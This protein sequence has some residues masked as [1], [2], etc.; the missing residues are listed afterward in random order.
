MIYQTTSEQSVVKKML[1]CK[2]P[3]Q[4]VLMGQQQKWHK[5]RRNGEQEADTH[6]HSSSSA[7]YV[8]YCTND[9]LR[10]PVYFQQ[11]MA[12]AREH[13]NWTVEEGGLV[14]SHFLLIH[15]YGRLCA[16]LTWGREGST[17]SLILKFSFP[18][19]SLTCVYFLF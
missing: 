19:L 9:K 14:W 13:Q 12:C 18:N 17:Y 8:S 2:C 16:S 1:K 5:E 6:A 11:C 3:M 4:Q 7:L 15:M 10:M